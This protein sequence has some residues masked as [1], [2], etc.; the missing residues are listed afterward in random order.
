MLFFLLLLP[1]VALFFYNFYWKRRNLPP[2]PTPLPLLGNL[3]EIGKESPGTQALARWHKQY[4]PVFTYWLGETPF[5]ALAD[6]ETI[7]EAL[8]KDGDAYTDREFFDGFYRLIRGESIK[9]SVSIS[10]SFS[11]KSDGIFNLN[12]TAWKEHLNFIHK[13]MRQ[14]GIGTPDFEAK[15]LDELDWPFKE[16]DA[17][18]LRNDGYAEDLSQN[19][20]VFI[21]ST[22]NLW[23]LGYTFGGVS[24]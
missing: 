1:L 18:L 24:L 5:V 4:G 23:L 21:G 22:V 19:V 20:D 17:D 16:T 10:L 15:L 2:G 3:L 13:S 6:Y 9:E 7:I 14:S 8:V 11:G 12:G